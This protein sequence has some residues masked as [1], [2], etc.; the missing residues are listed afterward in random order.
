[1]TGREHI[2]RTLR[3]LMVAYGPMVVKEQFDL[4]VYDLITLP[5]LAEVSANEAAR[6]KAE[7][8]GKQP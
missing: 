6:S 5:R 8:E 4:V 3:D 2:R 7:E 1:M